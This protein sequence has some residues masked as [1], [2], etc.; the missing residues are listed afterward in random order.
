[1]VVAK[2]SKLVY[3]TEPGEVNNLESAKWKY[4]TMAWLW[5]AFTDDQIYKRNSNSGHRCFRLDETELI[6]GEYCKQSNSFYSE[7][8]VEYKFIFF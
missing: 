8:V 2:D 1:M 3:D 5:Q 4:R 7:M 6:N